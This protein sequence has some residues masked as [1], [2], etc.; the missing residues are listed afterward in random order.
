[1]LAHGGPLILLIGIGF[2]SGFLF[3]GGVVVACCRKREV[4]AWL[5]FSSIVFFVVSIVWLMMY[6]QYHF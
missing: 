2:V 6:G 5:F 4:A 3:L 1:M